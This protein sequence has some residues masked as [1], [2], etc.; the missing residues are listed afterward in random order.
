MQA[1]GK[2]IP[3]GV[4]VGND[5]LMAAIENPLGKK[6]IINGFDTDTPKGGSS[7]YSKE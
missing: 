5:G 1:E 3:L 2:N 7:E 4:T 6:V